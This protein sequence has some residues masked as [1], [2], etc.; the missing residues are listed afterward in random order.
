MKVD[1]E[2]SY[3]GVLP[4]DPAGG[5]APPS[6]HYRLA[7]RVRHAPPPLENPRSTT[8]G[9]AGLAL[10]VLFNQCCIVLG[11]SICHRRIV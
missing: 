9:E 11:E 1:K 6:L 7:L 2:P 4:L 10:A 8:G 5:S 3:S